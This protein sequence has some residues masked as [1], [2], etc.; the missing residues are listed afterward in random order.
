MKAIEL[1]VVAVDC[2]TMHKMILTFKF[3][4]DMLKWDYLAVYSF[5]PV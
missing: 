5:D 3:V 2:I 4:D 1:Y